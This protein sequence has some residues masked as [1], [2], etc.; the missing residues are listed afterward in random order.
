MAQEQ[1][2]DHRIFQEQSRGPLNSR[3]CPPQ[4]KGD[5]TSTFEPV[6]LCAWPMPSSVVPLIDAMR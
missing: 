1:Q 4:V 2:G 3:G 5:H 6:C